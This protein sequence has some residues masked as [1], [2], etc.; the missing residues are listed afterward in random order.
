MSGRSASVSLDE[1]R[2][3]AHPGVEFYHCP[4]FMNAKDCRA[5]SDDCA[6]DK[7]ADDDTVSSKISL[8]IIAVIAHEEVSRQ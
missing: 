3:R 4:F 7:Y 1:I 5:V 6:I 2:N 8:M